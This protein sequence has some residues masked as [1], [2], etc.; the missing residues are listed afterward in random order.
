MWN[1]NTHCR[2]I[3]D[4]RICFLGDSFFNGTNAPTCLGWTGRVCAL[5]RRR[6]SKRPRN[7]GCAAFADISPEP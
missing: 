7:H 1:I 5:A 4:M 2:T 6:L 3:A